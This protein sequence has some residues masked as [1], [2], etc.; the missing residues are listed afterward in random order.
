MNLFRRK[1]A[2]A[3]DVIDLTGDAGAGADRAGGL[4]GRRSNKPP[5]PLALYF[6]MSS[7]ESAWHIHPESGL[8]ISQVGPEERLTGDIISFVQDD[9]REILTEERDTE[10][11]LKKKLMS[12][13]GADIVTV[14]TLKK[15]GWLYATPLARVRDQVR[16]ARIYS[17]KM[18][19]RTLVRESGRAPQEGA[20]L[21]GAAIRGTQNTTALVM[22]RVDDAG[23]LGSM[24]YVPVPGANIESAL[25]NYIQSAKL[26]GSGELP[27]ERVIIFSED[28]LLHAKAAVRP[29]PDEIE[30]IGI[31][32]NVWGALGL[33]V[34]GTTLVGVLGY[35]GFLAYQAKTTSSE[36]SRVRAQTVES[37]GAAKQLYLDRLPTILAKTNLPI[38]QPLEISRKVF[39]VGSTV[40]F[41]S[42]RG[43]TVYRVTLPIGV[44]RA[45]SYVVSDKDF[46][47]APEGCS[48]KPVQAN[49]SITDIQVIYECPSTNSL[50]DYLLGSRR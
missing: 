25:R 5:R 47:E 3:D 1:K 38:D 18:L 14:S 29:Y 22:F 27:V 44:N 20:Y 2:V 31:S 34:S 10:S 39:R 26:A 15:D 41:V 30:F 32:K 42:E 9:D 19:L 46:A 6:R 33:A 11:T 16:G 21:L 36:A 13:V 23:Y 49:K 28:D 8:L 40:D 43:L 7:R 50:A 24:Q 17:G 48:R 35:A 37:R 12:D 4:L 45:A